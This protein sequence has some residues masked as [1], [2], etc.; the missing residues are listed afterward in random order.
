MTESVK[1]RPARKES[2]AEE[3][4]V[5]MMKGTASISNVREEDRLCTLVIIGAGPNG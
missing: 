4:C 1:A 5:S 3:A 2:L